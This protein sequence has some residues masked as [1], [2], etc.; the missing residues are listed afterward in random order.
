ME[1]LVAAALSTVLKYFE[2]YE[3]S[4]RP[5]GIEIRIERDELD[6][7]ELRQLLELVKE[8]RAGG[9]NP[10]VLVCPA[11]VEEDLVLRISIQLPPA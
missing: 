7:E 8:L 9:L 1:H 10:R 2:E 3:V 6:E 4:I 11:K 5:T